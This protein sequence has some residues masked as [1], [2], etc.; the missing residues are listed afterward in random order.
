MES[1]SSSILP[2]NYNSENYINSNKKTIVDY[3]NNALKILKSHLPK[4]VPTIETMIVKRNN[5]SIR[6]WTERTSPPV[7]FKNGIVTIEKE[8]KEKKRTVKVTAK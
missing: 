1:S 8:K 6:K 7:Y 5:N 4:S 2:I 3:N